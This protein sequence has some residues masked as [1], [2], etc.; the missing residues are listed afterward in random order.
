MNPLTN[1]RDVELAAVVSERD[2]LRAQVAALTAKL[3]ATR[4]PKNVILTS[5]ATAANA[6]SP[7]RAPH[8]PN[9]HRY[10][11]ARP[12]T[13]AGLSMYAS[14]RVLVRAARI[15]SRRSKESIERGPAPTAGGW[16]ERRQITS[17]A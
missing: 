8:S 17:S 4:T 15:A 12:F 11:H 3:D 9:P 1:E 14:R 5:R 10:H 2:A 13:R 7:L 6:T 16:T